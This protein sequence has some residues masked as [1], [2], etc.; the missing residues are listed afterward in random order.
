MG[1]VVIGRDEGE[2]LRRCLESVHGAGVVVYVDS[3]SSDGSA[4]MA[5]ALGAS[6]VML[7][8]SM[9]FTAARARNAG[10]SRLLELAPSTE[11][12]QFVDGDCELA[13]NWFPRASTAM[14]ADPRIAAVCGRRRERHPEASIYNRLC[15]LEWDT[16]IGEARA[17]GGDALMRV[18][19]LREVGGYDPRLIAGEEPEL[20]V[21]LRQ[22]GYRI[23]RIDSE[24][25]THDAAM[26][27]FGQWWH[28]MVRAGHAFA[29]G[30]AMHGAPP[31]RHWVRE[32]R[33][34]M[35]WGGAVPAAAA[36]LAP[37]TL[38]AS[39]V[40]LAWAY[41][42]Q[43]AR[44]TNRERRRRKHL[45]DAALWAASCMVAKFPQLQGAVQFRLSA[46]AGW[47]RQVI[48]Y[49]RSP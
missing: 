24:M 7:D 16:P 43:M 28:R 48:D 11:F 38:G 41:L 49:K 12:V 47:H 13:R 40:A 44:I 46:L 26:A 21:R 20:C 10:L 23:L 3:G 27:R 6:V 18:A 25:T 9:P 37:A 8:R 17:C 29:E 45:G 32:T 34:A 4:D 2:R 39:L 1:I 42:V 35:L 19:A 15:D 31:E 14:A 5:P 36:A 33:S 30:A 22:R